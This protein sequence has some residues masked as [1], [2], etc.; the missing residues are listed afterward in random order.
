MAR[1]PMMQQYFEIKEKYQD[2]LLFYRLGDFYEMFYEDAKICSRELDLTLTGRDCGEDERAPMCGMPH[3]S[4][5]NYISRLVEKG[6]KVA[7]CE[8]LEDPALAKGV[9]KRDVVRIITPGTI[10]E[11]GF[12]NENKNNYLCSVYVEEAAS[13]V[14]FMDITSGIINATCFSGA[15]YMDRL[16]NEIGI[17]APSEVLINMSA[18][19]LPR[20]AKF[21]TE[22]ISA[23][24][25]DNQEKRFDIYNAKANIKARFENNPDGNDYLN[26]CT[27]LYD[28]LTELPLSFEWTRWTKK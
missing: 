2:Y 24:V 20:I 12:L 14:A 15:D 3:H 11:S 17:F 23:A 28:S 22:K 7:I 26:M 18:A 27:L 4:A 25:S 13:G 10:I 8:Q 21:L 9:V 6:Y 19:K 5:D 16:L 1:T